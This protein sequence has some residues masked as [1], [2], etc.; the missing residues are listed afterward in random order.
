MQVTRNH[1]MADIIH[2]NYMVLHI[3]PRF[4]ITLGFEDKSL[5]EVCKEQGINISFL[6]D[7]LNSY[8]DSSYFPKRHL[9]HFPVKLIIKYLRNTHEDYLQVKMPRL[10]KFIQSLIADFQYKNKDYPQLLK[11]FFNDY[12]QEFIDHIKREEEHVFPYVLSIEESYLMKKADPRII[13]GI[14]TYSI[15][16][17]ANDNDNIED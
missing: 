10:E 4:G 16:D 1:K 7:I 11:N 17:Y 6:L 14:K 8:I 5:E 13:E 3:L 12:K 15:I 9:L 2:Q